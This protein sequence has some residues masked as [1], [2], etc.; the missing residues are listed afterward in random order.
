M[1][2]LPSWSEPMRVVLTNETAQACRVKTSSA[3]GA[4]PHTAAV[5]NYQSVRDQLRTDSVAYACGVR[6]VVWRK[7]CESFRRRDVA[8]CAGGRQPNTPAPQ[9][10]A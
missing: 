6:Q 7:C 1:G 5:L 3:V 2:A 4:E 10:G 8:C 9:V